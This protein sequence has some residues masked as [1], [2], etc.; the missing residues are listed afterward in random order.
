VTKKEKEIRRFN[1]LPTDYTL[2]ELETLLMHLG[3]EKYTGGGSSIKF[4][5]KSDGKMLNFHAPHGNG[6]NVIKRYL[7]NQIKEKLD[8][9]GDLDV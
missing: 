3:F 1:N 6:E 9:S 2:E 7:M 5:R 4:Y 8:E